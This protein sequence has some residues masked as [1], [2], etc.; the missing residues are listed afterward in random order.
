MPRS[1]TQQ[2]CSQRHNQCL[3]VS[4]EAALTHW[5]WKSVF[6]L[7]HHSCSAASSCVALCLHTQWHGHDAR[8]GNTCKGCPPVGTPHSA[9]GL[10]RLAAAWIPKYLLHQA[11]P[12]TQSPSLMQLKCLSG[13]CECIRPGCQRL[14][15]VLHCAVTG[16]DSSLDSERSGR[17]HPSRRRRDT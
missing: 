5:C 12:C 1:V 11:Q 3:C 6:S 15:E 14:P 7:P 10:S 17:K 2:Q 8:F 13:L 9:G 16:S 4:N